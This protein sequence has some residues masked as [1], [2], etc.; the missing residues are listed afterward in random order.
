M[1]L[2][3]KLKR[4]TKLFSNLDYRYRMESYIAARKPTTVV[5]AEHL[6]KQFETMNTTGKFVV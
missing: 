6:Q 2:T 1:F 3:T 5:E 4:L